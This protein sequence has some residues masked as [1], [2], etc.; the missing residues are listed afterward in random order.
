MNSPRA[1]PDDFH[2]HE[3][4][5]YEIRVEGHLDARRAGWL[6]GSRLIRESDVTTVIFGPQADPVTRHGPL[7][8]VRD[9]G[10][11]LI[12]LNPIAPD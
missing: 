11:P 8:D 3:P 6:D 1:L 12:S 10:L 7:R 5:R 4:G 9:L 2:G